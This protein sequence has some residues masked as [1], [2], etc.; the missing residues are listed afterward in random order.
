MPQL[1]DLEKSTFAELSKTEIE[2]YEYIVSAK[3]PLPIRNMPH[4]LQG[5]VG[6][7]KGRG[8]VEIYRE[9]TPVSK[10]GFTSMKMTS[11]VRVNK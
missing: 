5:A 10:H 7:L 2:A 6:K 9:S 8:L 3:Q 11:C 4:N 1:D